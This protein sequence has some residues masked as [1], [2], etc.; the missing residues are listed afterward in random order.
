MSLKIEW[1]DDVFNGIRNFN[2]DD[3]M[4]N[5][6]LTPDE[7]YYISGAECP[8]CNRTPL[9]KMR[10]RNTPTTFKGKSVKIYNI[11][12]CPMCKMFF[13]SVYTDELNKWGDYFK[14]VMEYALIS[15]EYTDEQYLYVLADSLK[16]YNDT[17]G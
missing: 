2:G 12:T 9:Y 15:K 10:A 17:L 8:C 14:P 13:A 16:Y 4:Y 5:P 11:F 1:V 3:R 6:F 7:K